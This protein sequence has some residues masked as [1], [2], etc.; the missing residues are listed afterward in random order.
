[1]KK[2]L[3]LAPFLLLSL[4]IKGQTTKD[5][6]SLLKVV[7]TEKDTTKLKTLM[8]ISNMYNRKG[9]PDS[10]LYFANEALAVAKAHGT[11]PMVCSALGNIGS[12]KIRLLKYDEALEDL[13]TILK[14]CDEPGCVRNMNIARRDIGYIY[15]TH[16]KLK[17]ALNFLLEA[18]EG[19]KK[20]KDT[21]DLINIYC[22]I[23]SCYGEAGDTAK[24]LSV[25]QK[26]FNMADIHAH[27]GNLPKAREEFL[28]NLEIVLM[29]NTIAFWTG[30]DDLSFALSKLN[31][32]KIQVEPGQNQYLKF[33]VYCIMANLNYKLKEYK[34]ALDYGEKALK[35]YAGEGNYDQLRDTYWVIAVSSASLNQFEKAYNNILLYKQYNDSVFKFSKLEAINAVEA[36]YQVEKKEQQI[37]TLNK[38]KRNKNIIVG[39]AIGGL[40]IVLGLLVFVIRSKNLQKKLF[41]KEKEIQKKELEQKMA[42]LE[43]TALRAQMN[44]HFIFNCLNSV[45]RFIITNDSEGA[46]HYLTTFANLI[47]QT[48]ENSGKKYI[49]L[50][51]ELK[52]LKT[53]ISMEQ[54]RSNNSFD[55]SITIG[56]EVDQAG[57]Y[58]PNMIVQPYIE[59]SIHHGMMNITG[60]KGMIR[61]DISKDTKLNFVVD[62]NGGGIKLKDPIQ[63]SGEQHTSM[64]RALTEKRIE[65]YNT[66]NEEKIELEVLD[67]SDLENGETGTRITF[68]FP[69]SN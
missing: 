37:V 65:M 51:D 17:E 63:Q 25:F 42:E 19:A 24:A 44:P 60:K 20:A 39:L 36:K 7:S 54:L 2:I 23:I 64:G 34:T 38:E 48:L 33:E 43:Q 8:K 22:S 69:L 61:L 5:L 55:H 50:K 3:F 49:A 26:A 41:N 31:E 29:N 52:Y 53:Y 46:N 21:M 1:M 68:K 16:H 66:L 45:N 30:K 59:N 6:D 62:D 10:A 32:L 18:E 12:A 58:I 47:R 4:F 28:M 14:I 40:L 27:S 11:I 15:L 56:P 35:T 57:I 67:K 13:F 9:M